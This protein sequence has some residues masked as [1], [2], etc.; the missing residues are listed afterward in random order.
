MGKQSVYD[1][2]INK[3]LKKENTHLKTDLRVELVVY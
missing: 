3:N 2:I 1:K